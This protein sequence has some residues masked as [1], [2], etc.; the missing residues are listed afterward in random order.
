MK[1]NYTIMKKLYFI[2]TIYIIVG[3]FIFPVFSLGIEQSYLLT[4]DSKDCRIFYDEFYDTFELDSDSFD[5]LLDSVEVAYKK[6]YDNWFDTNVG[7]ELTNTQRTI[8]GKIDLVEFIID[9]ITSETSTV[10]ITIN[11][12]IDKEDSGNL[13]WIFWNTAVEEDE[14]MLIAIGYSNETDLFYMID[15]IELEMYECDYD[16]MNNKITVNDVKNTALFTESNVR[17]LCIC[18]FEGSSSDIVVD[19]Y[20]NPINIWIPIVITIVMVI[21]FVAIIYIYRKNK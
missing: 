7:T 14:Q 4:D 17:S 19:I 16:E 11:G 9:D 12:N 15:Y 13:V 2:L 18:S 3:I 1:K 8:Y 20:S 10:Q 5:D 21:V 6:F